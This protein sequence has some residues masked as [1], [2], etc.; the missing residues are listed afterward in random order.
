MKKCILEVAPNA[1]E[2]FNY[3][4]PAY[5]LIEGG[6]REKQIMIA[7]YKNA[8]GFYPHPTTMEKFDSELNGFIKGKG[9][10]QFYLD[11]PL[12]KNLIIR[13]IKYRIK[14]INE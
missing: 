13:M 8:V 9:S 1:T 2:L 5:T 7:G 12:P 6:K 4:I 3:N 14:L 10:L 11:K